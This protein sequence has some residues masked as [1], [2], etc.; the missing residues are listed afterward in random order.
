M[1]WM[2][3]NVFTKKEVVAARYF[4]SSMELD[5][6]Q[7]EAVTLWHKSQVTAQLNLWVGLA[8]LFG[9]V[10]GLLLAAII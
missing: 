10:L 2:N 7:L 9:M 5:Q 8:I 6:S 3:G 1:S 4:M